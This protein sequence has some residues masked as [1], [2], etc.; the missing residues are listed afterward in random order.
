MKFD[1]IIGNPP[2][3]GR[4]FLYTKILYAT[5]NNSKRVSWLCP[6][7]FVD[8][9]YKRN[10]TF[11][12]VIKTFEKNLDKFEDVDPSG[13]DM[14]VAQDSLGIFYFSV[15]CTNPIDMNGLCWR[16]YHNPEKIKNICEKIKNYC[17]TNNLKK[18]RLAPKKIIGTAPKPDPNFVWKPDKWYL[19]CSWV[20]GTIGDW[21]WI[22]L[23]GEKDLPVK[24][25]GRDSWF[26]VWEFDNEEGADNFREYLNNSDILKFAI[27]LEK[28]NQTN[29]PNSFSYYPMPKSF[30]WKES[31]LINDIG[32]TEEELEL[33]KCILSKYPLPKKSAK[34]S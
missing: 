3:E 22:T 23:L 17:K 1:N 6:T 26:H 7:T 18:K 20:R 8:G 30:P 9:V 31:E 10:E 15:N 13:F 28:N 12:S 5:W 33:I 14:Q 2:Y 25:G 4:G 16:K 27:H 34:V 29:N 24:G 19:G 21:T 11:N 32:I